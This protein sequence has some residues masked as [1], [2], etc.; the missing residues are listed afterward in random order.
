MATVYYNRE[1]GEV[2]DTCEAAMADAAEL[3]DFG[4]ETNAVTYMGFPN[5]ELPYIEIEEAQLNALFE[6]FCGGRAA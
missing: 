1:T 2:F 6:T 3:Y 5:V 4:D